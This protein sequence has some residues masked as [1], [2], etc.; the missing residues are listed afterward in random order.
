[1]IAT[2]KTILNLSS[3]IKR[4]TL[5]PVEGGLFPTASAGAHILLSIPGP[6]RVWK[7]AYSLVSPPDNRSTYE[8]IVRRVNHFARWIGLAA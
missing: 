5:A 7:N 6:D 8:I 2:I 4:I 3:Q 1:M